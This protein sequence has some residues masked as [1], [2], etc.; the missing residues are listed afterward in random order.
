MFASSSGFE[1]MRRRVPDISKVVAQTGYSPQVDLEQA[2]N[3]IRTW[4][5]DE[6]ILE[7]AVPFRY[8][9]PAPASSLIRQ[10][11]V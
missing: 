4:M 1:D 11:A 2:L 9:S 5:H 6:R 7:G 8:A 3:N 10:A